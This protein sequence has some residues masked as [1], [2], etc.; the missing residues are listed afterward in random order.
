MRFWCKKK[1]ER[2]RLP[3]EIFPELLDWKKGDHVTCTALDATDLTRMSRQY[4]SSGVS[5]P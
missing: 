2:L 4:V 3:H 1:E 5:H